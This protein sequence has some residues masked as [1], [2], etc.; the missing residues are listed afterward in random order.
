MT[1]Y[2]FRPISTW[3]GDLTKNRRRS[4]FDTHHEDTLVQLRRE[5]KHLG[6]KEVMVEIAVQETEL[7]LDGM[8]KKHAKPAH[9]GVVLSFGSDHGPLRYAC[10]AFLHWEDNLRGITLGLESLRRVERYGITKR[11][12]QYVGWRQI[13]AV[14][15][16][17][18]EAREVLFGVIARCEGVADPSLTD[19]RLVRLALALAHPD[20]RKDDRREWDLAQH[21]AEVLAE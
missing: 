20:R 2:R 9:P 12:E 3:P 13:E 15:A 11:G 4:P 5:L 1:F 16:S 10:D 7:R 19:K 8:P 14:S 21:A 6:A 18:T 17:A